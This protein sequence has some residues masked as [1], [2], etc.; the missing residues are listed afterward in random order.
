M[1][2]PRTV[3]STYVG[4]CRRCN[5]VIAGK[6]VHSRVDYIKQEYSGVKGSIGVGHRR[7]FWHVKCYEE[8][9]RET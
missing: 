4:K 5:R 1:I 7:L 8:E 9:R 3:L 6:G 2:V